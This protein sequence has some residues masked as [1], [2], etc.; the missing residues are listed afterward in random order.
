MKSIFSILVLLLLGTGIN[1]QSKISVPDN[2]KKIDTVEASCGQ[3][4]FKLQGKG[5]DLA[6]RVEGKAYFVDGTKIDEHGDAHADDGFC[7]AI[8]KAA[9]Q[10]KV[11]DNRFKVTYFKLLPAET[12]KP[13]Q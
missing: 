5:C 12:T 1:A 4:Q 9:V 7:E 8:R 2:S 10:G 6:V 3:C 11:A 13:V